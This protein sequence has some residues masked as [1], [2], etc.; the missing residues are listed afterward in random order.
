MDSVNTLAKDPL[1]KFDKSG[2]VYK[3]TCKVC[4]AT[5]VG[6]TSHRFLNTRF[7]EHKNNFHRNGYYNNF[8]SKHKKENVDHEFDCENFEFLH[9]KS[10]K[11]TRK[12]TEMLHIQKWKENF[13]NLK[14]DLSC[15]VAK[16]MQHNSQ[17]NS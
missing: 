8:L 14:I 16:F 9:Y 2:I 1:D 13:I 6:H 10:N 5:Y 7:E 17:I 11:S 12:F 3:L 15:D 4:N